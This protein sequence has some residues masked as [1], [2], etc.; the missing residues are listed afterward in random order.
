M[1][2]VKQLLHETLGRLYDSRD[3]K[4]IHASD[5]TKDDFCSREHYLYFKCNIDAGFE[6]VPTATQI[7]WQYGRYIED[8]VRNTWLRNY[9]IGDWE[10]LICGTTNVQSFCYERDYVSRC[11]HVLSY[12]EPVFTLKNTTFSGSIDMFLSI[13]EQTT[14]IE[15]KTIDKDRFIKLKSPDVEHILRSQLY[16]Y[17]IENSTHVYKSA[18][19]TQFLKIIY[20]SKSFGVR[21]SK[22]KKYNPDDTLYSPI[23]EFMI[24]RDDNAIAP[25]LDKIRKYQKSVDTETLPE[26]ICGNI[27]VERAK[28]CAVREL[29]FKGVL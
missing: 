19:N 21:D 17:L 10:C 4:I 14:A 16:L 2:H 29:C 1:E 12:K 8:M 26:R 25:I 27:S 7:T 13:E 28:K 3:K 20:F 24:T 9:V 22:I 5:I 18:I 15:I 6:F 23:K 11:H